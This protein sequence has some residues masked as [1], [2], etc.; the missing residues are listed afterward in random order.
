MFLTE[1]S[2][3]VPLSAIKI[4]VPVLGSKS[5][6]NVYEVRTVA[7]LIDKLAYDAEDSALNAHA[8]FVVASFLVLFVVTSSQS[9]SQS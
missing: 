5:D 9:V 4:L 6:N 1:E 3:T 7:T 2:K 8:S